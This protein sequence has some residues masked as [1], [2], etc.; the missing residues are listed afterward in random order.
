MSKK[1]YTL[2][3]RLM[4]IGIILLP[5]LIS[6]FRHNNSIRIFVKFVM[7]VDDYKISV[8]LVTLT[9]NEKLSVTC[10]RNFDTVFT[11]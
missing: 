8:L 10:E 4:N 7:C 6:V 1:Q 2:L 11:Y 5:T 9:S 3:Y